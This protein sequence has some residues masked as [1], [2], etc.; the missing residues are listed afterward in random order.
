MVAGSAAKPRGAG[1]GWRNR[2]YRAVVGGITG[3]GSALTGTSG[4]VVSMPMLLLLNW[5]VH[6]SL[7]T[8]QAVQLPIA[9]ASTACYILLRPGVIDWGLSA[10]IAAGLA[11][12]C[13]I[14]AVVAHKVPADTLKLIVASVLVLSAVILIA[15][16]LVEEL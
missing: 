15:K 10:C 11:P 16:L 9:M 1:P 13:A 5:P 14:G 12:C 2:G 6:M 7:G 4:P 3:F 8:A